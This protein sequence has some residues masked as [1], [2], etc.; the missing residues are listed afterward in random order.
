MREFARFFKALSDPTRL[1]I[2]LLL[3]RGE[4]SVGD[5]TRALKLPQSTVSRHLAYL[6]A[7]GWVDDRRDGVRIIYRLVKSG[8]DIQRRMLFL[9]EKE[10]FEV[11]EIQKDFE[12]LARLDEPGPKVTR[13]RKTGILPDRS[14]R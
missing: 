5:L 9:L 8:M 4:L 7:A 10:L 6:R 2:L 12:N 14:Y 1:R 11:P 13:P 3:T